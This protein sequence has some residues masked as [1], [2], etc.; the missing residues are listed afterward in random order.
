MQKRNGDASTSRNKQ[1]FAEEVESFGEDN[2]SMAACYET[3]CGGESLDSFPHLQ[4]KASSREQHMR[5]PT[6]HRTGQS[7]SNANGYRSFKTE[8]LGAL[9]GED[10]SPEVCMNIFTIQCIIYIQSLIFTAIM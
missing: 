9:L 7:G 5:R 8:E 2:S 1:A 10:I 3:D 6:S 4:E